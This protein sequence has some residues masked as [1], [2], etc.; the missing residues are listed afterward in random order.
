MNYDRRRGD[1]QIFQKPI[2]VAFRAIIFKGCDIS[3]VIKG[4]V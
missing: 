4:D 2:E 3:L 1:E